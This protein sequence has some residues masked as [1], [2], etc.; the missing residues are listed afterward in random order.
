MKGKKFK[1]LQSKILKLQEN[2]EQKSTPQ[3]L[4]IQEENASLEKSIEERRKKIDR[5]KSEQTEIVERLEKF[6]ESMNEIDAKKKASN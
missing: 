5:L 1:K 2:Q 3:R 4:Q 6:D